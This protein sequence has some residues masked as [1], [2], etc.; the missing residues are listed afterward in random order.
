MMKLIF[1]YGPPAA[2]KLTVANEL[3]KLTGYKVFSNHDLLN[4]L[5]K[6]MPFDDKNT[7]EA[8]KNLTK[9]IRLEIFKSCME[10]NINFIT[11]F[12]QAGGKYFDFFRDVKQVVESK[13]GKVIF[14]Q[15]L[16]SKEKLLERVENESRRGQKIDS[17]EF[18]A[19]K[20]T[21]EPNMFEK[22]PDAE[23]LTVDNTELTPQQAAS[24]IIDYYH[25][26][27]TDTM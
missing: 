6:L 9:K 2:G 26:K 7:E 12:G 5:A 27:L 10:N 17:K 8:R 13:S 20:I 16:A 3:A 14:V 19:S 21:K 18:L 4:I 11:T 24:K 15:L 25:L 1:I 23:H 22:F